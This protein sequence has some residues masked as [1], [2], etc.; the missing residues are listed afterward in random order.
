MLTGLAPQF[1]K[2][3]AQRHRRATAGLVAGH[4]QHFAHEAHA[5]FQCAAIAVVAVVVFG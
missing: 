1:F 4:L 5:V 2:A 3:D